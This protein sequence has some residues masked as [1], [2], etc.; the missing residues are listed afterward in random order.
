MLTCAHPHNIRANAECSEEMEAE[1]QRDSDHCIEVATN[2]TV[3]FADGPTT[4]SNRN[5]AIAYFVD[6][7]ELDVE[8]GAFREDVPTPTRREVRAIYSARNPPRN[9]TTTHKPVAGVAPAPPGYDVDGLPEGEE[10]DSHSGGSF[11]A[12]GIAAA[13]CVGL[14]AAGT[15][16]LFV[17][18]RLR[19]V[20]RLRRIYSW[21]IADDVSHSEDC[22]KM[23]SSKSDGTPDFDIERVNPFLMD[24]D[25]DSNTSSRDRAF[26]SES[27][28]GSSVA[29]FS[30][31]DDSDDSS[32][33]SA[34]SS[35]ENSEET[36]S[37]SRGSSNKCGFSWWTGDKSHVE[38]GATRTDGHESIEGVN[39]LKDESHGED[40]TTRVD[41]S[42]SYK[43]PD[44][45]IEGVNP[46]WRADDNDDDD[47]GSMV[48][49]YDQISLSE[50][51]NNSLMA[52]FSEGNDSSGSSTSF[53]E[54]SVDKSQG[55][56]G[57]SRGRSMSSSQSSASTSSSDV[58]DGC[59]PSKGPRDDPKDIRAGYKVAR[60]EAAIKREPESR[61]GNNVASAE[62]VS[63]G[64]ETPTDDDFF[65]AIPFWEDESRV[66]LSLP[67]AT[68]N[69][70]VGEGGTAPSLSSSSKYVH[71]WNRGGPEKGQ[72]DNDDEDYSIY[73]ASVVI[74][75][76]EDDAPAEVVVGAAATPATTTKMVPP[77][78]R[79]HVVSRPLSPQSAGSSGW[80]SS[81]DTRS[82]ENYAGDLDSF[83]SCGKT[84]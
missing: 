48:S 83:E 24:D 19:G 7:F 17:Y 78:R 29:S 81:D 1:I 22:T 69:N 44:F 56:D 67:G 39:D 41:N 6:R 12:A 27:D 8:N 82:V 52:S 53:T 28:R 16:G 60:A 18:R 58:D 30:G 57:A 79:A 59:P 5:D 71:P 76:R 70:D 80:D 64:S 23:D 77:L 68:A 36:D 10:E 32:T 65:A 45:V 37:E 40:G 38:D 11:D 14:V 20:N 2:V 73:A 63:M 25:D 43:T 35:A 33:S 75:A 9:A 49:S 62:D 51:V 42:E 55:S 3:E 54:C 31:S 84:R 47:D 46:F 72:D 34:K 26:Q 74:V 15:I 66:E 4:E 61:H 21:R 50:S 13:L